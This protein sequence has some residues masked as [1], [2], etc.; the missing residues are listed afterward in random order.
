MKTR[1]WAIIL[2]VLII[3]TI[4]VNVV[5]AVEQNEHNQE[6]IKTFDEFLKKYDTTVSNNIHSTFYSN[7]KFSDEE[8]AKQINN[9]SG[10]SAKVRK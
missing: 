7:A 1:L 4:C 8:T 6:I 9:T 10:F 3:N 2:F 5:E